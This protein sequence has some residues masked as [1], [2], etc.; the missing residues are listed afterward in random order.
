MCPPISFTGM[1]DIED[2]GLATSC[3]EKCADPE[4]GKCPL[5]S[6]QK[7][8]HVKNT[9]LELREEKGST[10]RLRR[11]ASLPPDFK[12]MEVLETPGTVR[13]GDQIQGCECD[14]PKSV[15]GIQTCGGITKFSTAECVQSKGTSPMH[16][17][18]LVLPLFPYFAQ[19]GIYRSSNVHPGNLRRQRQRLRKKAAK[20]MFENDG[21]HESE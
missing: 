1:H 16:E 2:L 11:S 9:F 20:I 17:A 10:T 21:A 12:H 7:E 8:M 5:R 15:Q 6:V 4:T 13:N 3:P 18:S 14:W 19:G